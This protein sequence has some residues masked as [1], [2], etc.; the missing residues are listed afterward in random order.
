[1]LPQ[2]ASRLGLQPA[3]FRRLAPLQSLRL[4]MRHGCVILTLLQHP[5]DQLQVQGPVF[6]PRRCGI[7][8]GDSDRAGARALDLAP[9][10]RARRHRWPQALWQR[11]GAECQRQQRSE[12]RAL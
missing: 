3:Q 9:T 8:L 11:A 5:V 6:I 1:M 4:D 7:G 10:V 12:Q 2:T